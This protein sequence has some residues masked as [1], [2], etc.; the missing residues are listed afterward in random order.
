MRIAGSEGQSVFLGWEGEWHIRQVVLWQV[1]HLAMGLGGLS[2][3]RSVEETCEGGMNVLHGGWAQYVRSEA[4][5]ENS[6]FRAW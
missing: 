3:R 2:L 5:V 1:G 4:G 6:S